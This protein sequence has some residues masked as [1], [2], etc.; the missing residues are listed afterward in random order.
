MITDNKI[1]LG[2]MN[3]LMYFLTKEVARTSFTDFIEELDISDD[4][5]KAIKKEWAK[6]GIVDLY[7]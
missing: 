5:Y 6:I 3:I 7:C 2:K 1:L 4:D